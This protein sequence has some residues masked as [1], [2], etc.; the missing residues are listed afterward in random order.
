M[1]EIHLSSRL[2]QLYPNIEITLK[3][4][5]KVLTICSIDCA[6]CLRDGEREADF[7]YIPEGENYMITVLFTAYSDCCA[8]CVRNST[9]KDP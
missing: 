3:Q 2:K 9:K 6:H 1:A 4:D 8:N 5:G 7:S